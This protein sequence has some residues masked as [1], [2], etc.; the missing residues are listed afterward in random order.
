MTTAERYR[1]VTEEML[2]RRALGR[3]SDAD[4]TAI[5]DQLDAL[6]DAMSERERAE[7]RASPSEASPG[8]F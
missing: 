6:W 7:G 2:Y 4:E 3:L 1:E 8:A 5:L